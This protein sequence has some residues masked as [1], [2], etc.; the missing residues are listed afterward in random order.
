M[1]SKALKIWDSVKSR[2]GISSL[3]NAESEDRAQVKGE[4]PLGRGYISDLICNVGSHV[5]ASSK[6][7]HLILG[8]GSIEARD[9]RSNSDIRL[10]LELEFNPIPVMYPTQSG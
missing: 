3:T 9:T 6:I 2:R 4:Q 8:S 7:I 10:E 1:R 5:T